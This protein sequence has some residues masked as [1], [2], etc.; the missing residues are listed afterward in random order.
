MTKC[1]CTEAEL[2]ENDNKYTTLTNKLK[3]IEE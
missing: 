1:N 3:E 2:N